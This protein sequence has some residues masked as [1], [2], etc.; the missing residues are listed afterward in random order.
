MSLTLEPK[1]KKSFT[2]ISQS[3]ALS[4]ANSVKKSEQLFDVVFK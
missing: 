4:I 1:W 2:G 3:F